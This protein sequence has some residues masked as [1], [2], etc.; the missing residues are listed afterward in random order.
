MGI[1]TTEF[2]RDLVGIFIG[3]F[4]GFDTVGIFYRIVGF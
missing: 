3:I 4:E 2:H 1:L